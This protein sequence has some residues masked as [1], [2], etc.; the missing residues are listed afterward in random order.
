MRIDSGGQAIFYGD[1]TLDSDST[2]LKIGD[3]Q[4]L[5]LY[6]DGSHSFIDNSTGTLYLRNTSS[7]DIL[8]RSIEISDGDIQLR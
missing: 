5:Q 7:V 3:S 8:L 4:D 1:V 2:K 6:H